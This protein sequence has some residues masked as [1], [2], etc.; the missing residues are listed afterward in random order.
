MATGFRFNFVLPQSDGEE[1][2]GEAVSHSLHR[3]QDLQSASNTSYGSTSPEEPSQPRCSSSPCQQNTSYKLSELEVVVESFH[4]HLLACLSP[5]AHTVT[6]NQSLSPSPP[7]LPQP[8]QLTH[9]QE[10]VSLHYVTTQLL[11]TL[12]NARG[13]PEQDL[14]LKSDAE[15]T[16]SVI[17]QLGMGLGRL[18]NI[19]DSAH[20]DLI[21]GVYEGGM[22]I[23]EC[24]YDLI[25]YLATEPHSIPPLA[26]RR[27]L[28]LGSG[29]GLPGIFALL[30]GA[31]CVHFHDYNREVLSCLTIPSVLASLISG[32]PKLKIGQTNQCGMVTAMES[33]SSKTKFYFGDWADF[34]TSHSASGE[35]PYDII[36][37]SET[38]YS[39]QSQPKLLR[40]MKKLTNQ[41]GG[42]VIMAA[43]THY[44]GVGGGVSMFRDLV[45]RDGHFE[46][47]VGRNITSN[48]PRIILLLK[49]KAN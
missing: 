43:K 37:T 47:V 40:A 28:E 16:S 19:A 13:T 45:E 14:N 48:V 5:L 24:A 49:P 17:M 12:I 34:A 29:I 27:V 2:E 30:C 4:E 31:E 11:Q 18:V 6:L 20:S 23:W 46:V 36:L 25:D 39:V 32:R 8:S 7:S 3:C 42:L 22:K 41:S 33:A 15:T 21:P 38:I 10:N 9:A 26:A 1:E 35:L 44:F